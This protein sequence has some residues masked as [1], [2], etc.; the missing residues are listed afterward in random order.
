[1]LLQANIKSLH[2]KN[3]IE[4]WKSDRIKAA[5]EHFKHCRSLGMR[6]PHLNYWMALCFNALAQ[7]ETAEREVHDLLDQAPGNVPG[8]VMRDRLR[9]ESTARTRPKRSGRAKRIAFHMNQQFHYAILR[10]LFELLCA[11]HDVL[12]SFE[13]R[14]LPIFRPDV[15][16]VCDA[17]AVNLR[18]FLPDA[19]SVNVLHGVSAGKNFVARGGMAADHVCV[20]S[21]TIAE[22][23]RPHHD[24][25]H[26]NQHDKIWVTGYLETD[27]LFRHAA[28]PLP[29]Q[30]D[31]SKLDPGRKT[32]LYAPT[33]N[34]GLSS[35]PLLQS[36][37]AA[38]IRGER[39]DLN[40]I[41]KPHPQILENNPQW[42]AWFH[43]AERHD[44]HFH[45]VEDLGLTM[46]PLM[47]A[48]D[49]IV[50]DAS[51][52]TFQFLA[53]DRPIV[54]INN[55]NAEQAGDAYDPNSIE[56]R[57][58]DVGEDISDA[59]KLAAAVSR[60]LDNPDAGA[61]RRAHY[62]KKIFGSLTDGRAAERIAERIVALGEKH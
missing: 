58:R 39:D 61:S 57:W 1:M 53:L 43:D 42:T 50:S 19:V 20:A 25:Q 46:A 35:L 60:G 31:P 12:L 38:L 37:M 8:L 24:N 36:R 11:E 29:F 17:Q 22:I 54:Q 27:P 16:I 10:P 55:L 41:T 18:D 59:S 47:L 21:D 15:V 56:W 51:N 62:R 6:D 40:I 7:P 44:Q 2:F 14:E 23:L 26:D 32:V 33:H 30:L 49:L 28:P 52:C 5:L 13:P 48:A 3:G 34:L 4:A 9:A 45:L